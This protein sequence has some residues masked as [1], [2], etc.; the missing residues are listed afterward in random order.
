MES[1]IAPLNVRLPLELAVSVVVG[2]AVEAAETSRP[3]MG[4]FR[5]AARETVVR[6]ARR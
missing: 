2:I 1:H 4:W 6:A 3:A 5:P